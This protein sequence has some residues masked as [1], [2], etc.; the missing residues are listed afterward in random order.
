MN[1]MRTYT[2]GEQ[3]IYILDDL[4][5][6]EDC[7]IMIA[8]AGIIGNFYHFIDIESGNSTG[9]IVKVKN[10][11]A[12]TQEEVNEMLGPSADKFRLK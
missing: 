4:D 3:F 10:H 2:S 6:P 8:E 11:L 5:Q 7:I 12:I 1:E 9:V